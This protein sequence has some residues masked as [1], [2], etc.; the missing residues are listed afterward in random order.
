M[1]VSIIENFDWK[2]LIICK[3]G[4]IDNF[5]PR[6]WKEASE[7][8]QVLVSQD[9][10]ITIRHTRSN[11]WGPGNNK[12]IAGNPW[13]IVPM[14]GKYY[15]GTYEWL[16]VGQTRKFAQYRD[17]NELY[18][19]DRKCLADHFKVKPLN[20]FYPK[21]GEIVGFFVST[22][23]RGRIFGSNGKERSNIVWYE[24][25]SIDGKIKGR[26]VARS[27]FKKTP[28]PPKKEEPKPEPKLKALKFDHGTKLVLEREELKK[29][30]EHRRLPD[31][32]KPKK[33]LS[34]VGKIIAWFKEI[35]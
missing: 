6:Y 11:K 1:D 5:D 10:S 21:G 7:I 28:C 4:G 12:S 9:G 15:A 13:M 30:I 22:L 17:L 25:P 33:R 23:A 20:T 35:F 2:K 24:L 16:R 29:R 32:Q 8:T 26:M 18:M 3:G 14:K 31:Y 19:E 34:L 27:E